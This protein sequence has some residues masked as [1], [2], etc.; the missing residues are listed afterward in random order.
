MTSKNLNFQKQQP[1]ITD[2]ATICFLLYDEI[3]DK[4]LAINMKKT[5]DRELKNFRVRHNFLLNPFYK[6]KK[7]IFILHI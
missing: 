2:N 1:R 7:D 6:H 4:M 5:E 3:K